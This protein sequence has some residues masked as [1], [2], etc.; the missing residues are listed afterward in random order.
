[1]GER[2]SGRAE[3]MERRR[4]EEGESGRAEEGESRRVGERESGRGESGRAEERGERKKIEEFNI[5]INMQDLFMFL[6]WVM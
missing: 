1:M 3:E 2:K 5:N 6:M 4:K